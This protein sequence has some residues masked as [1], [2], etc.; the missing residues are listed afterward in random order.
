MSSAVHLKV[1]HLSYSS[2]HAK[3]IHI[4]LD[5]VVLWADAGE[6]LVDLGQGSGRD[7]I[8]AATPEIF[9]ASAWQKKYC[10]MHRSDLQAE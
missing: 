10:D 4:D 7:W 8:L 6:D 5:G 3:G 2:Q 1:V 9:T